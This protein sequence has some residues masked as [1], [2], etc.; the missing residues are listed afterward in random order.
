ML[1]I[2]SYIHDRFSASANQ[3][4][5]RTFSQ[6]DVRVEGW[7]KGELL[8]LLHRLK[9]Q[10]II[11]DFQ[12]EVPVNPA[13]RRRRVDFQVKLGRRTHLCELKAMCISQEQQ[14]PRNLN[15]YFRD[16]QVGIIKDFR[17]LDAMNRRNMWVLAFVYPKPS[18]EVWQ[19]AIG[20]IPDEFIHWHCVSALEDY[21]PCFFISLWKR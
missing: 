1:D 9:R 20:R 6:Y 11:N 2:I 4:R 21:P 8:Y 3:V 13:N 15:F 16:D 19:A 17:K 5:I 12:R 10:H 7:F 18:V 14:T